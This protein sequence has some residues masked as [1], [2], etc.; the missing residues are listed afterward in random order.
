MI[1][2]ILI[3]S[4]LS[5]GM[6]TGHLFIETG[7]EIDLDKLWTD[8]TPMDSEIIPEQLMKGLMF[9]ISKVVYLGTEMAVWVYPHGLV[10]AVVL[11]LVG[12]IPFSW[13]LYPFLFIYVLT[14]ERKKEKKELANV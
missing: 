13:V 2:K 3:L 7:D 14:D 9:F 11:L 1:L 8:Y 10:V 5:L 12:I 4:M 6:I